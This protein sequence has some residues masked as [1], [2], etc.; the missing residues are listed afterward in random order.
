M[1]NITFAENLQIDTTTE[2]NWLEIMTGALQNTYYYLRWFRD[3][4]GYTEK[5]QTAFGDGFD[6]EVVNQLFDGFAQG[7]F[8]AIPVIEIVNR[9]DINGANGAFSITTGKVYL[10][11]D[12][13]TENANNFSAI[14][15]VLLEETGHSIDAKINV[16]DAAGDEGDIFARLVQGKSISQEELA[17]LRGEDD[18]A[19]VTVDGEVLEIE[20]NINTIIFNKDTYKFDIPSFSIDPTQK[21]IFLIHGFT[22]NPDTFGSLYD[23]LESLDK[24]ANKYEV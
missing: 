15:D 24:K 9:S 18:T 20:Q 4:A 7:D 5:L 21:T 10:A 14:T 16:V 13:I 12:F 22:S 17:V 8:S 6:G 3:D 11:A 19:T 2:L 1:S 23:N